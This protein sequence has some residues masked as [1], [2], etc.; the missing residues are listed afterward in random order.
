MKNFVQISRVSQSS[1][2]DEGGMD[3]SSRMNGVHFN[4]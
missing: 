3:R 1:Q 4:K 2:N